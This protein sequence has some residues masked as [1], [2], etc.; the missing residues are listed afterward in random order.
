MEAT[1]YFL[2]KDETRATVKKKAKDRRQHKANIKARIAKSRQQAECVPIPFKGLP[3]QGKMMIPTPSINKVK[4][5][6][7]AGTPAKRV[8]TSHGSLQ[9]D[10]THNVGESGV[11]DVVRAVRAPLSTAMDYQA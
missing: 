10:R 6:T 2:F 4:G 9:P 7:K 5:R 8:P 3:G 1:R 11:Q